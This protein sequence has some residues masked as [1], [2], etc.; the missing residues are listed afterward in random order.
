MREGTGI[1]NV[2]DG[3]SAQIS[4][5]QFIYPAIVATMTAIY[6]NHAQ[7]RTKVDGCL[8]DLSDVSSGSQCFDMATDA[9]YLAACGNTHRAASSSVNYMFASAGGVIVERGNI[10]PQQSKYYPGAV[11]PAGSSIDPT[12]YEPGILSLVGT[13][14]T[15]PNGADVVELRSISS[16]RPTLTMPEIYCRG[17]KTRL[18]VRNSS[19]GTWSNPPDFTGSNFGAYLGDGTPTFVPAG[20]T[21]VYVLEVS[22]I[23]GST[24]WNVVSVN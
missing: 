10:H 24:K 23:T 17:Q 13:S 21:L 16:T 20:V 8:F 19:A 14:Y 9:G 4:D 15:I 2:G 7:A 11:F 1:H 12:F 18:Y 6:T 22:D 5:C 3:A